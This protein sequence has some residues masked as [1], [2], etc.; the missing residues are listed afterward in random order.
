MGPAA[1]STGIE[2]IA[3]PGWQKRWLDNF[4]AVQGG[5]SDEEDL[6]QDGWTDLARRIQARIRELPPER[7]TMADLLE[8][9]EDADH[10][11]MDAEVRAA[12]TPLAGRPSHP[13]RE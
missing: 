2:E 10:E 13:S 9:W 8:A 6:V 12:F 7:R 1:S 11:K 4:T 5:F 3:T